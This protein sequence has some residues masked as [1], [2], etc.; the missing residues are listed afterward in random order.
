[1]SATYKEYEP[2]VLEK[3]QKIE[4]E[5]LKDFNELC[6]RNNIDY[7]C[8]SGTGIGVLRHNGFIPWDDD[9]D[10]G[11]LR[12][13]YEKFLYCAEEQLSDKYYMLNTKNDP[14]YPLMT[15]RM[16]LKGTVF[17]E[18]CFKNLHSNFGI[19]LDL[20]CFDFVPD[21]EKV[22]KKECRLAWLKS[23]FMILCATGD[24]VLYITGVKGTIVKCGCKV[25]HALFHML[26]IKPVFFF[27]SIEKKLLADRNPTNRVAYQFDT[28]L[29]S[30]LFEVKD[31][32]PTKK[33]FFEN[34]E[35]RCPANI[36]KIT[37]LTYGDYMTLP[38]PE[39]RHNHPPFNLDFGSF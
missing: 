8:W 22:R 9:I 26:N 14:E 36:E 6:D 4:L 2:A 32:F 7:F 11:L 29:D 21:D 23:K 28:K 31:L 12:A 16:V 25:V 34:T 30:G 39:M 24:P 13:D 20:Y 17:Q 37:E 38:P 5:M 27:N 10:I 19:F 3:I 15:T 18:E 35:I 33:M 1:M